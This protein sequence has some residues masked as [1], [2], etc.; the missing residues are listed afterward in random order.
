MRIG[1]LYI[2][3]GKYDIFWKDFYLSAE[4]YFFQ[5]EPWIREY[6]VF[7]DAP[8]IYG[9]E[10]NGHIHR[11][12]QQS[13]GWPDNTLMRFHMFLG[14]KEQLHQE[15]DYLYFFN[16]NVQFLQAIGEDMIPPDSSNG[17]VGVIHPGFYNVSNMEFDYERRESSVA[18][19]PMGTGVLYYAGG[20]SGGRT[21]AYLC[22]CETIRSMVDKDTANGIVALWHDESHTNRYFLDTPP[23]TLSA[24]YCYPEDYDL[25]FEKRILIRD[26]RKK[27]YGGHEYLR[28][29]ITLRNRLS[30]LI[31]R[32]VGS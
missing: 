14:I 21:D 26:K 12:Y 13:L 18:C 22:F 20:V 24:A 10:E 1:I 8:S 32:I 17:L 25:P 9:E 19:I 30:R 28:G 15:T 4:R 2:C 3:T 27:E 6:Y 11:I 5:N 29:T 23:F 7:T 31:K 16:A